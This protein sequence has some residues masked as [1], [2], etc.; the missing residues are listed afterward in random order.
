MNI[1]IDEYFIKKTIVFI[2]IIP[3]QLHK[4]RINYKNNNLKTIVE[5]I[6]TG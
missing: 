2:K 4:P 3:C 5:K 6:S 1:I